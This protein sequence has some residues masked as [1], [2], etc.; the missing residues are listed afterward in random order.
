MDVLEA[1]DIGLAI[2]ATPRQ[3]NA[4]VLPELLNSAFSL[5]LIYSNLT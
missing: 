2:R 1:R 3:A 4:T 5:E